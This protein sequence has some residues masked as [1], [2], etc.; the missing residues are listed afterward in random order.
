MGGFSLGILEGVHVG[1]SVGSN[2]GDLKGWFVG[3]KEFV[4]TNESV[5][6]YRN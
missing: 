5:V 4:N 3:S 2:D 6:S 1:V